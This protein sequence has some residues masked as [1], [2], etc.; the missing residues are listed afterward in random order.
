MYSIQLKTAIIFDT[1]QS[2]Q[3][4]HLI[5]QTKCLLGFEGQGEDLL[6]LIY[7]ESNSRYMKAYSNQMPPRKET[8]INRG[9]GGEIYRNINFPLYGLPNFI[10]GTIK[11]YFSQ[12]LIIHFDTDQNGGCHLMGQIQPYDP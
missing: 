6:S 8:L 7:L 4:I 12:K 5:I 3:Q 10:A 11:Y 2:T 1:K 9:E